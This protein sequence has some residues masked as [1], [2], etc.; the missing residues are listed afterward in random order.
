MPVDDV[1]RRRGHLLFLL[2]ALLDESEQ[3]ESACDE[4]GDTQPEDGTHHDPRDEDDS[5]HADMALRVDVD[6]RPQPEEHHAEPEQSHRTMLGARRRQEHPQEHPSTDERH[7]TPPNV[8]EQ[9]GHGF[10]L[11]PETSRLSQCYLFIIA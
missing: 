4:H 5:I 9:T 3:P 7:N 2:L 11:S 10:L 1:S 8:E 6:E